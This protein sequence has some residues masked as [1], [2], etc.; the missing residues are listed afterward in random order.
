[1]KK[2]T[3]YFVVRVVHEELE[4]D[5]EKHNKEMIAKRERG[6]TAVGPLAE[7]NKTFMNLME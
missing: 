6:Y 3:R 7:V 1:M 4:K 5:I 2:M